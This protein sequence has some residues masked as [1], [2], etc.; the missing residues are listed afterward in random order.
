MDAI[1]TH[2]VDAI[3]THKVDAIFTRKV[4]AVFTRKVNGAI[5]RKV[6]GVFRREVDAAIRR[7]VNGVSIPGYR[8][9][10]GRRGIPLLR[11]PDVRSALSCFCTEDQG[12]QAQ[13]QGR[14]SCVSIRATNGRLH[15]AISRGNTCLLIHDVSF[16]LFLKISVFGIW[17]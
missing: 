10:T 2:K 1:F 12:L 5:T 6:D 16:F 11:A 13:P 15:E 8:E 4:D 9:A 7:E 14:D 17:W 3:F